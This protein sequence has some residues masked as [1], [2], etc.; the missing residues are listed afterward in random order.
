LPEPG[1]QATRVDAPAGLKRE[2]GLRDLTLFAITC[3]VGTRW[4][5]A[6]AHAG[7]GSVTLWLLTA[8]FFVVPLAFAVAS[9]TA[10]YPQSGGL[11]VWARSDFG[12][13]HGFVCFWMYWM[14]MAV[15]FP[16]AAMFYMGAALHAIGLPVT[17][18]YVL[19][20]SLGAIVLALGTNLV[21]MKIGKWT[22]NIGGASAWLVTFLF[23]TLAAIVWMKQG[24]A[25]HI[26]ILP[27]WNWRTV[28]LW[29]TISFGMSGLEL[30]GIMV[31][32]VRDPERTFPR[33]AWIASPG[34]T[35]FYSSAT[36]ALL[37]LLP[38]ERISEM[39]GLSEA[40]DAAAHA[41]GFSWIAPLI[42]LLVVG[43]GMGQLGGIGTA[44]SRLPFAAGADRLLPDA[45]AR[46]HPRWQ[47]PHVSIVVLGA[48]AT[49]LLLAMQL[50]DTLRAAY[51]EL[52][53]LMIITGYIPYFYIFASSW[54]AGN[55]WSVVAGWL[56]VVLTILCA[57]VP[58]E[59]ITNVWLFEGKLAAGTLL[60]VGSA[61]LVYRRHQGAR[62]DI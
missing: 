55:R 23:V 43:S 9:L 29:A 27:V 15:W 50:G 14:G 32:E 45:F 51:D 33:A 24:S 5:A 47:T 41:L 22:E 30:A 8:V 31:A 57:V 19:A 42:T 20:A 17:R 25:T 60:V 35:L 21:G 58:T 36:I 12:P 53:S 54:K 39:N 3:I 13:W 44:I 6:A 34:I 7:P 48:V 11:Y 18:P 37:V 1:T 28:N 52:V 49:F 40:G 38:P 26:N 2:L 62:G 56:V 4:I 59:E 10:K 61:W 16:S 46:I